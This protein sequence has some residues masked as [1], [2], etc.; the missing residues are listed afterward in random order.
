MYSTS[1]MIDSH[2]EQQ[3]IEQQ[4]RTDLQQMFTPFIGQKISMSRL[5]DVHPSEL[6]ICPMQY[7]YAWLTTARHS[8]SSR[9]TL[10]DSITLNIGT[11]VHQ[12]IQKYLPIHAGSRMIGN[13]KCSSCGHTHTFCTKP[14]ECIICK[15]SEL[16]YEELPIYYKG[17]AGHID[18]V[19]KTSTGLAIVDYK[20]TTLDAIKE[21][22]R[23]PS[24]NYLMQ[25]RS[26]ALLLKLQYK[27]T[28]TDAFLVFIAK[29]KPSPTNFAIYQEKI[30]SKKLH[31]TF[32]FLQHQRELKRKLMSIKTFD[33]FMEL[34]PEPC[35]NPFCPVCKEFDKALSIIETQWNNYDI[36]PLKEFIKEKTNGISV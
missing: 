34:A 13:W 31:D 2:N 3:P 26:Y 5:L 6:P 36:F 27:V 35:G 18:T 14:E 22:V 4:L 10:R 20:T 12:N 23:S 19:Y 17:F 11:V 15:S 8:L 29:E 25:I 33:E 24:L 7:I 16:E 28:C 30:N 21:K 9:L 32:L 1:S